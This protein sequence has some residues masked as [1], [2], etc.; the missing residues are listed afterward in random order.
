MQKV[1]TD[2]LQIATAFFTEWIPIIASASL[3]VLSEI[4]DTLKIIA[5]LAA[6]AYTLF[7][8]G[9]WWHNHM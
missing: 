6:G 9:M 2:M 4:S 7:R 3:G 5:L 8:F 1:I